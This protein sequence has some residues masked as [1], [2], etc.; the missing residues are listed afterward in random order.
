M[1]YSL[2]SLSWMVKYGRKSLQ[3]RRGAIQLQSKREQIMTVTPEKEQLADEGP[4]GCLF[5]PPDQSQHS[6]RGLG[7]RWCHD[8]QRLPQQH[9]LPQHLDVEEDWVETPGGRG[10]LALSTF[11]S[12]PVRAALMSYCFSSLRWGTFGSY[13]AQVF[14]VLCSRSGLFTLLS[15]WDL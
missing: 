2:N 15:L 11:P 5:H 13:S 1:V 14:S 10:D 4:H 8:D 7:W 9:Q 6:V 12:P 3:Y